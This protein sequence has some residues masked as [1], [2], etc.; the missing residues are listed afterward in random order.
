[1]VSAQPDEKESHV[2]GAER[3][4]TAEVTTKGSVRNVN[5][6]MRPTKTGIAKPDFHKIN[7]MAPS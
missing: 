4:S 2:K 7:K 6:G 5:G 1:V 3:T